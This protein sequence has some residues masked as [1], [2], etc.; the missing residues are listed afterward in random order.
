MAILDGVLAINKP[1]HIS[2]AQCIRDAQKTFNPSRTF[3]PWIDQENQKRQAESRNQHQKR[4]RRQRRPAEVKIGHGGTLDPEATGVLILGIGNGTKSLQDFLGC[5]KSYECTV[6]FGAATD[7]YD[8]VGK[9]VGRKGYEHV[10]K[11]AVEKALEEFR[12]KIMQKPPIFSALRMDGK[13]LYEYARE[14]KELPKEIEKREVEVKKLELVEWMDG[15][16]HDF[17]WPETEAL[18]EEKEFADKVLHLGAEDAAG[19]EGGEGVGKEGVG[20]AVAEDTAGSKR[21]REDGQAPAND[22]DEVATE[23]PSK[24]GKVSPEPGSIAAQGP[25]AEVSAIDPPSEP[26]EPSAE[27]GSIAAQSFTAPVSAG[28]PMTKTTPC[29]APAVRL[30]MEVTSGFYVRS[31]AHD[32]G[33]AV[34][35]LGLMASLVRTRQ[36]DFEVGNN[37]LEYE[38]LQ[39][40]EDIWGPQVKK[41]LESWEE[42]QGSRSQRESTPPR[43]DTGKADRREHGQP[44]RGGNPGVK[45]KS[46]VDRR[47]R[48]TSSDEE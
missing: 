12:G 38:E 9:I 15:G 24:R 37:V 20:A 48:N 7:S 29:P 16:S 40:S 2:S 1:L 31:L 23:P 28:E 10:T 14:G 22:A 27:P 35:S 46:V 45:G 11:E 36:G 42:Q 19:K 3:A 4:S 34:G 26:T 6:L 8:G 39:K 41:L 17:R 44:S 43:H 18:K 25:G 5:S 32:L 47:R 21:K 33:Q 13:R 30:R